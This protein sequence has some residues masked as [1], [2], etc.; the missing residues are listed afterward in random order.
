VALSGDIRRVP[1]LTQRVAEARRLGYERILVP[2]GTKALLPTSGDRGSLDGPRI[3]E[4]G[5]LEDALGMLRHLS[6]V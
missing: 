1:F 4:V 3:T 2:R 6:V 5:H